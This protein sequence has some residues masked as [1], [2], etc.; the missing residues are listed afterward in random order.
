MHNPYK[1]IITFVCSLFILSSCGSGGGSSNGSSSSSSTSSSG[2]SGSAV[3][4]GIFIDSPVAGLN[5]ETTTQN[6]MTD[7]TGAFNY[8][9]GESITFSIGDIDFP[10]V[11]AAAFLT[12][13]DLAATTDVNDIEVINIAR[14]LQSL[15]VDGDVNNGIAIGAGAHTMA[16]GFTPQFDDPDFENDIDII[17]LVQNSGSVTT[18]LIDAATAI[19]NLLAS[20]NPDTGCMRTHAKVGQAAVLSTLAHSVSGTATIVDDC[21]IV[22]SSFNYDGG[23]PD[24]YFYGG[25]DGVY[26]AP[27]GFAIGGQ[28]QGTAYTNATVTLTL[29]ENRDLDDFN[30]ISVWCVDFNANFGSGLFQD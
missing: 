21:T 9:S 18:T 8:Q 27:T 5:Y 10:A 22:V 16:T 15:D 14:L 20:F 3:L 4:S 26:A 11:P 6:G 24:V 2:S 25:T 29:P 17:S 30:G 1:S 12:P 7:S 19:N 13:F 28:I 23:G